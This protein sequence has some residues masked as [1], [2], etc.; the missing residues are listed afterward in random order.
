MDRPLHIP[1]NTSGQLQTY[2]FALLLLCWLAISLCGWPLPAKWVAATVVLGWFVTAYRHASY[3]RVRALRHEKAGWQV[4]LGGQWLTARIGQRSVVTS[5]WVVLPLQL[6]SVAETVWLV[7]L[8]DNT[9]PEALRR[10]RR[11]LLS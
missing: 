1:V 10:L 7:L 9:D 8:S 11:L 5:T 3:P 2:L 4:L 6:E